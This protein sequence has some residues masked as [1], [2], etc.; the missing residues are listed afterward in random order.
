MLLSVFMQYLLPTLS[1]LKN[2]TCSYLE[3]S[4]VQKVEKALPWSHKAWIP[5]TL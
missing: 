4:V 5:A 3:A 1:L 2:Q